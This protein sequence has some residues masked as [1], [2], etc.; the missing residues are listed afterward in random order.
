MAQ[1]LARIPQV[2]REKPYLS[3]RQL[4]RWR[5]ERRVTTYLAGGHV[6]F[7]LDDIDRYIEATRQDAVK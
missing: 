4:R 3:E 2:L 5:A 1:R 7:D 6:L